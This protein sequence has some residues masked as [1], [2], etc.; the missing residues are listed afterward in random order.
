MQS[1]WHA[2]SLLPAHLGVQTFSEQAQIASISAVAAGLAWPMQVKLQISSP[3]QLF[4]HVKVELQ[5]AVAAAPAEKQALLEAPSFDERVSTLVAILEMARS[6]F[7]GP[8]TLN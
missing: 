5:D 2:G 8:Q 3:L 6:E 1:S 4:M 7:G